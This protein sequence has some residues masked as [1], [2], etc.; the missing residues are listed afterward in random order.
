MSVATK[1]IGI[2]ALLAF[3]SACNQHDRSPT[4]TLYRNSPLDSALRIQ[5]ATFDADESDPGYN[6]NNCMMA[7]RLLNANVKALNEQSQPAGFWCEPGKY[8]KRGSVPSAFSAK[9]PTDS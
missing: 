5:W 2:V 6:L 3:L 1:Q 9:F 4:V 7:A 8:K